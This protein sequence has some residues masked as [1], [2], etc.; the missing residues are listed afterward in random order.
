SGNENN[1]S[2][3]PRFWDQVGV[4]YRNNEM[5]ELTPDPYL[6][7]GT[8]PPLTS[9]FH[10]L[11][12][13]RQML[14]AF[15]PSNCTGCGQ[16]WTRCPESAIGSIVIS[17]TALLNAGIKLASA[18]ALQMITSKLAA[19]IYQKGRNVEIDYS[20]FGDF[21]QTAFTDLQDKLPLN[22]ER[23]Q[24][25]SLAIT[26]L[27]NHIGKLPIARTEAFFYKAEHF[28]HNSGE[29]LAVVINSDACKSCGLCIEAC[30]PEALTAVPQTVPDNTLWRLWEQL[31]DTTGN[32]IENASKQIGSLPAILLSRH[33]QLA[34]AGGDNA[35]DGSGEKLAV[36]LAIAIM[37]FQRQPLVANFIKDIVELD[38]KITTEIKNTLANV[39]PS[40]DLEA[41]EALLVP[42]ISVEN[43]VKEV[44][45]PTTQS[46]AENISSLE[47]KNEE[48]DVNR[49]KRLVKTNQKLRKLKW[50][51]AEGEHGLGRSR[52][53][54][55]IAPGTLND[56]AGHWPDNPFQVPVMIDMNGDTASLAIGLLEGQLRKA[57]EGVALLQQA[58]LE[59][60]NPDAAARAAKLAIVPDWD[61]LSQTEQQF[62]PPLLM[63]GNDQVLNN[64]TSLSQ[65][66]NLNL[67][68][69]V[70][71]F[72]DLELETRRLEPSL[73]ALAQ[74]KAFV[75]QTSISHQEHFLQGIKEAFAFAGP[76]LIYIYTPSP[77]RHGFAPEQTVSRANEA[78]NSRMFPLFKYNPNAE[79]VFGSRISLEGNLE[80]EQTWIS[81]EDKSFTPANW[82]LSEQR[83]ASYFV[84][85]DSKVAHHTVIDYLAGESKT[86]FVAKGDEYFQVRPEF[87]TICKERQ[88][89]WRT[90]Q[91]L[92]GLVTPFTADL[93]A[94]LTQQIADKHKMELDE[95]KQEYES[96]I[97][98]L[99][100]EMEVEMAAKVKNNLMNLAG[101]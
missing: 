2:S 14:P 72:T 86:A 81:L 51:L 71:L 90:L 28:Q 98:K 32:S 96:K 37:E 85:E 64:K 48:I 36:R 100:A 44:L 43:T 62:C 69:K 45:N 88:Q 67:P 15:N 7:T 89:V 78:V 54:L 56:W 70:I 40:D 18:E 77:E 101:Y 61:E 24:A 4:L 6:T 52:L 17:P 60:K 31:P 5:D 26:A 11:S 16:C 58:H 49:L 97:S 82:A 8:I 91:E 9:T 59:L 27:V 47:D 87:L 20:T 57:I 30:E 53:S 39:L 55:A 83:F 1:Y 3:L 95:L 34:I 80:P 42:N 74:N 23:K 75:L 79:G 35:E 25:A 68:I 21:I 50:Q 99:R 93:E 10:D 13:G 92:A 41:L 63:L 29:F 66:L 84:P 33:C 73:L 22:A 12:I 38:I 94:R 76:A 19:N 65:L 46:I